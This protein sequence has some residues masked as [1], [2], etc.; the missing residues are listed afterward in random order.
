MSTKTCIECKYIIIEKNFDGH[1]NNPEY[2][3][4]LPSLNKPKVT[5]KTEACDAFEL[6]NNPLNVQEG[7][8]H[9]KQFSIQPVEFI[10]KNNLGFCEGNI[11]KYITRHKHKNGLE[12]LKKAKHYIDLLIALEYGEEN[13]E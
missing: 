4:G 11:I 6:K 8:K 5:R 2:F 3:C 13:V 10:T 12:D 9:Y 7:G 1:R